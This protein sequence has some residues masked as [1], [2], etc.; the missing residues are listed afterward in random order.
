MVFLPGAAHKPD[1]AETR[2]GRWIERVAERHKD[3][4]SPA[5]AALTNNTRGGRGV[6]LG[7]G[8]E[9]FGAESARFIDG[10]RERCAT[11]AQ[12]GG[13]LLVARVIQNEG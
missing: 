4:A 2:Q 10:A 5:A 7:D 11:R 9:T 8:D 13:L 1:D 12:G 3:R 6:A